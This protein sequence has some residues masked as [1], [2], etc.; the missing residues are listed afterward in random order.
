MTEYSEL[1]ELFLSCELG[2]DLMDTTFTDA[3]TD[4]ILEV[5]DEYPRG[6]CWVP[7]TVLYMSYGQYPHDSRMEKLIIDIAAVIL[8]RKVGLCYIRDY[9][10]TEGVTPDFLLDM[11]QAMKA[12]GRFVGIRRPL[13]QE[14]RPNCRYH[15]HGSEKPCYRLGAAR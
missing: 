3:T 14:E 12:K 5:I 15:T 10:E 11:M 2:Y 8:L 13:L 9:T 1:V 4:A 6:D 7:I